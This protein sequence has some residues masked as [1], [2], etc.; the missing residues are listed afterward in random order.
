MMF[1]NKKTTILFMF[2]SLTIIFSGATIASESKDCSINGQIIRN[3]IV[4]SNATTS[5]VDKLLLSRMSNDLKIKELKNLLKF[6][7]SNSDLCQ[8]ASKQYKNTSIVH[9][10]EAFS[11]RDLAENLID[12]M[13]L[14]ELSTDCKIGLNAKILMEFSM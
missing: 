3:V 4:P 12:Q 11:S 9:C 1:I 13:D 14:N 5:A 7:A 8:L 10:I 2:M 6:A